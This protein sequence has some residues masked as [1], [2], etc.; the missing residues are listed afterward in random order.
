MRISKKDAK[1]RLSKIFNEKNRK[2]DLERALFS[3]GKKVSIGKP[4]GEDVSTF[5]KIL[6]GVKNA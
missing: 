2:S 1:A 5:E 6:E 4:A 3:I